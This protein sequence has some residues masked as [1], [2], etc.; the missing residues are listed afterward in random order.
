M[1]IVSVRHIAG[2]NVYL[3]KPILVAR[4]H[5]ESYTEKESFDFPGFTESLLELLPGLY[6][7]HCAKGE[8][9]G[10]VERLHGGT[11]FG[12]IVEHVTI[13]LA[14]LADLD[15]HYGKTVYADGPGIYDIVMECKSFDAQKYLLHEALEIVVSL[16]QGRR[17]GLDERVQA[18]V[19]QAKRIVAE[20]QLG[21]S[22]QAIVDACKRRQIPVRRIGD[23]SLLELGYG[24]HKKRVSATITDQT[25][26][27]A[28]DIASNKQLT[29]EILREGGIPVPYGGVARSLEDALQLFR[30]MGESVVVK[31]FD[32]RQGQGVSLNISAEAEVAE[33]YD[34]ARMYSDEVLVESY[35]PGENVR[36][37]VV[38]GSCVAVSQRHPAHVVG[39]GVHTVAELIDLAN[40]DPRR[41]DGHELPLT[42][43]HVDDVVEATLEKAGIEFTTVPEAGQ[44]VLLR[45]S[46]NLSTGGEA[47]DITR[48]IHPSYKRLAER[49]ARLI[50]LDVCGV[51]MVVKELNEPATLDNCAV[52]EVNAAPGIRMH[53]HPSHGMSIDV[54]DYIVESLYPRGHNGRIP[55]IS[56]TGTNGKT[57]TT[58]LIAYG[59][60]QEG[61]AVGYTTTGGVYL[62]DELIQR[63]DTTGPRSAKL[64]LSNPDVEVAVLETARGGIMRGGLAYDK[65]DVA[66]MTNISLDHIGQD[67]ID[68]IEDLVHVKSLVAECVHPEGT[69]VLNADDEHLVA[70][71]SRLQ[72][73]VVLISSR[74][75][76][77]VVG[78]HLATGGTAF[79]VD[80]GYVV[81]ANG[82][83]KRQLIAIADIPITMRGTIGFHVENA[84]LATAALRAAGLSRRSVALTLQR[85]QPEANRGRCM[86]Y[87]MPG[88][89]HVI[90][91]YAHNAAGF[92]GIGEWVN[93]LPHRQLCG[94]VGVP[95]DRADS[96]IVESAQALAPMFDAFIVKEDADK[97]GR[98]DG[99][100]A[101]IMVQ[102][103]RQMVPQ[104]SVRTILSETDALAY[105]LETLSQGDIACMF[106]ESA[107]P[108]E[109]L[110]L[111]R[112]GK[113]V[114][115]IA[116]A[117]KRATYAML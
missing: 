34:I 74:S 93:Q 96:V 83:I 101:H 25:S 116:L 110:L 62:N 44:R 104:K 12:H 30:D 69:V 114:T 20:T 33:A 49:S 45:E 102:T 79:Y 29:K 99:E 26:C 63:G 21:P 89:F 17:D 115:D 19:S 57:T 107:E 36:L 92:R 51:D 70:L 52:I 64:I 117:P 72:S 43:L 98:R 13:E 14:T 56:V 58:R 35:V 86:I 27:V 5:L 7:H 6:E 100:V 60:Q 31:P 9:G 11:Y 95:G 73:N 22:T 38:A 4:V 94:I 108:L 97:R 32:G 106:Y 66:V 53:Q 40:E 37:L 105:A 81:E 1:N 18:A 91:D 103:L 75:D 82:A 80:N 67:N 111:E 55:I 24:V 23:G 28:V 88:G 2:P 48:Q 71:M 113:R 85:F 76:N 109:R 10:F 78:R 54:A 42:K 8:P 61:K 47:T 112:G 3:Y 15:V 41:G 50:G 59:M 16:T 39:D 65:A 68:T 84:L 77:P 46:A 90:L 87:Q